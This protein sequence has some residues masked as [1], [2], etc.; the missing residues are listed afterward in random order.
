MSNPLNVKLAVSL[1]EPEK[2][3]QLTAEDVIACLVDLGIPIPRNQFDG[4]FTRS[5]GDAQS[6][7]PEGQGK[8]PDCGD[9]VY[10]LKSGAPNPTKHRCQ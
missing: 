5:K 8:C 9:I 10:V 2:L 4:K 3:P 1:Y 7:V 6:I